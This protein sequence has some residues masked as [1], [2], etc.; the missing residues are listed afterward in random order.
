MIYWLQGWSFTFPWFVF[1]HEGWLYRGSRIYKQVNGLFLVLGLC[2]LHWQLWWCMVHVPGVAGDRQPYTMSTSW[3]I[4]WKRYSPNCKF[5][6]HM[7]ILQTHCMAT[8]V[9]PNSVIIISFFFLLLL[10]LMFHSSSERSAPRVLAFNASQSCL[11]KKRE[12]HL[13]YR[14]YQSDQLQTYDPRN[15]IH[16]VTKN[17]VKWTKREPF[18]H[19]LVFD[20]GTARLHQFVTLPKNTRWAWGNSILD[21]DNCCVFRKLPNRKDYAIQAPLTHGATTWTN[22]PT[23]FL[24]DLL[25][26]AHNSLITSTR[27]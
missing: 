16:S 24:S 22:P 5:H 17:L 7:T 20:Q 1:W 3:E 19:Q 13:S 12:L 26:C 18:Y 14:W 6:V 25:S 15:Q 11:E 10:H 21:L 2:F 23:R 27:T 8:F 4:T 9:R